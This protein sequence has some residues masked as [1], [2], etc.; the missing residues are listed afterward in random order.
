MAL[1]LLLWVSWICFLLFNGGVGSPA[2]RGY[3]YPSVVDTTNM[4]DDADDDVLAYDEGNLEVPNY[5]PT[6]PA[7]TD[8]KPTVARQPTWAPSEKPSAPQA[9]RIVNGSPR[10]WG[11]ENPDEPL[12]FPILSSPARPQLGPVKPQTPAGVSMPAADSTYA[13]PTAYYAPALTSQA[14]TSLSFAPVDAGYGAA[15]ANIHRLTYEEVFQYPSVTERRDSGTVSNPAGGYD[16]AKS[17]SKGSSTGFPSTLNYPSSSSYPADTRAQ[18]FYPS[19]GS[20]TNSGQTAYQP[21]NEVFKRPQKPA[22]TQKVQAPQRLRRPILP[23]PPP[24][25]IIQSRNAYRRAKYHLS[26]TKYTPEYP[27][28]M[29]VSSKGAKGQPAAPKVAKNPHGKW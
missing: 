16:K 10:D 9:E 5:Q 11:L 20:F 22:K 15:G 7:Y 24:S 2:I 13:G 6:G 14:T 18:P 26:H 17:M 29:A 3:G 4:G 12:V 19:L 23:F 1:S 21:R 8:G 28:P 27:Q 25:Y